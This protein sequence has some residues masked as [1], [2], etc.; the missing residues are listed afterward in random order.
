MFQTTKAESKLEILDKYSSFRIDF[1]AWMAFALA[2]RCLPFKQ[3]A[4]LIV[5]NKHEYLGLLG[6]MKS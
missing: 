1:K 5:A 4:S 2:S 3:Y 6:T